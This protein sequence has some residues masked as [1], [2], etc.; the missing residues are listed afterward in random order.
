MNSDP[1]VIV[2]IAG[3]MC[4]GK[5]TVAAMLRDSY[6]FTLVNSSDIVRRELEE[7]KITI[8]RSSQRELANERRAQFGGSYWMQRAY[9]HVHRNAS[10][11]AL[12]SV[13]SVS[14]CTYI[15]KDLR[16][17]VVGV[18]T[19]D[20]K[21]RFRRLQGR[22]DGSRD[23]LTF[24]Q[25]LERDGVENSGKTKDDTNIGHVLRLADAL[26]KNDSDLADLES[27]VRSTFV[28]FGLA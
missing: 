20:L 27:Q 17:R 19:K 15:Q 11:I 28:G 5:D 9:E 3:G 25:F 13:Y 26:I 8:S 4:S 2:G 6:S 12:V 21:V 24:E 14:E 7:L 1:I 23:E 18:E 10:R 22:R 16:G